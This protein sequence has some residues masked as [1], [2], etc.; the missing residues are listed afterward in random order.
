MLKTLR[1]I[2]QDVTSS[3]TLSEA[4]VVLVKRISEALHTQA[5]AVY[6]IDNQSAEYVLS[7]QAGLNDDAVGHTRLNLDQG[8]IG[9]VGR[10]EEPINLADATAHES[11]F[12]HDLVGEEPYKAFLGVPII[13]HRRLYGVL[14]LQQE[15][16]VSFDESEEAFL[17]TVA[18]QLG[19]FIAHA[20]A[21]GELQSIVGRSH[22]AEPYDEKAYGGTASVSGVGI[23]SVVVVY[24]PANID[25]VPHRSTDDVP[26]EVALFKEALKKTR[27]EILRLGKR[28]A[29]S[30]SSSETSLFDAYIKIL[31]EN[32]LGVEVCQLIKDQEIWAQAALTIVIKRYI[33]QIEQMEDSYFRERASDF[34]DLGRR[35]LANLQASQPTEIV[36]PK[37]TILVGEEVTAAALAEVPEGQLKG[38]VS[39]KGSNN[40]HVAILAR[41]LGVPTVMGVRGLKI[42]NLSTRAMIVDGYFGQVYISPSRA[43]FTEFKRLAKEEEELN[44]SLEE[45]RELPAQTQ[46]GYRIALYVNTGLAMDAGLSLSVGGEGV[47]LYRSE[48]PFITR[49]RF[50]SEE[51]QRIIYRQ[52]LKAFS[53]L[54]VTMRTLDIGGD[55]GLPYFPVEEDN[56]FLGWRGIRITLDHPDV[57]L[58]Q[59]RA[60][61]QANAGLNNLRI[62]LPMISGVGEVDEAL[63]LIDQAYEEVLEEYDEITKPEVGVMIEVPSAVYQARE[64]ASRVD[65]LSVGSNDLTQYLLA[66]DRNNDRVSGLYDSLHPAVLRSLMQV[67]EGGHSE[68]VPVSICG[69]MA[70]EPVAVILLL[71]MGFD[72]LSMNSSTLP[73]VKWI[74]RQFSMAQS[75]KTLGEVLSMDNPTLIRFHLEKTLDQA[76]L[77]GLIRAGK[78]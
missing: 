72:A 5:V 27:E 48:V 17:I 24:P 61:L 41:A 62:M 78:T 15:E 16:G 25:A 4:L 36:Y 29:L 59:V 42:D 6:L 7:A 69:E 67:V 12:K 26:K 50:P 58:M 9:L 45:L 1:R 40:S 33:Q 54:M 53:P 8:L 46:D 21:R 18:A 70:S 31:D 10:R 3:A 32:S 55:K 39:V 64:L 71:A 19:G 77:G 44:E 47:G 52:T 56:P 65:F 51:E 14:T 34:R 23:G 43:L 60:M 28:L 75:R 13:H 73:R 49:D 68:G 35:V 66:V 30:L 20:E 2:V 11:F 57:F 37:R 63:H 38:L 74:V 22:G 76:G